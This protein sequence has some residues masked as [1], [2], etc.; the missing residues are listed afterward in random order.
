MLRAW[1]KRLRA[2]WRHNRATRKLLEECD[3]LKVALEE[4][5]RW[6]KASQHDLPRDPR[7][8]REDLRRELRKRPRSRWDRLKEDDDD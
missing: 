2:R 6:A 5:A 4:T 1:L 8:I 3:R 7:E